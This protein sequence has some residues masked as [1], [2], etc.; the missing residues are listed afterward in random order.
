MEKYQDVILDHEGNVVLDA[1]VA[2]VNQGTAVAST[3]YSDN[4]ITPKAN[5]FNAS[6]VDGSFSFYAAN[7]RYDIIVLASASFSGKRIDD[8][9]L[10]D[11]ST[12]GAVDQ[13]ADQVVVGTGTGVTS[14]PNFTYDPDT[15]DLSAVAPT[16]TG[17]T[18][19]GDVE[20]VAGS[21]TNT[22]S[23]A[24]K[25][26]ISSGSATGGN[27]GDV[28]LQIAG[29]DAI[30]LGGA[31]DLS[32]SFVDTDGTLAAN[33]DNKLPTQKAVKT[34]ADTTKVPKTTTVNGHALSGDITVTA[35]DVGAPSG[36]GVST[37]TNTGDET[38][39][40]IGALINAAVS[41]N[42]PVDADQIGLMDS[43]ASNILKKLSW[44]NVKATLKTYFDTL[45]AAI[46]YGVI[47][48]SSNT[49]LAA[50]DYS[51][52]IVFTSSFTQTL[53]AAATLADG[54]YVNFVNVGTGN[55]TVD[56]NSSELINGY[57]TFII[58]PGQSGR[59]VTDGAAFY[60]QG[61]QNA[62]V[63]PVTAFGAVMNDT[64]ASIRTA[65]KTALVAALAA[66][67][68]VYIPEG[69]LYLPADAAIDVPAGARVIGSNRF[70][71]ASAIRGDGKIFTITTAGGA[72]HRGFADLDIANESTRGIL[73]ECTF[74]TAITRM[75]FDDIRFGKSTHHVYATGADLVNWA[76]HDC[77][78]EDSNTISRLLDGAATFIEH[79]CYT[80]ANTGEGLHIGGGHTV[81]EAHI[82][83]SVFE[84]T[85]KSAIVIE[86]N[87]HD[88]S[89]VKMDTVHFESNG[90]NAGE[91]DVQITANSANYIRGIY[92]DNCGYWGPTGSQ[93]V[94]I[95]ISAGTG[96]IDFVRVR[97]GVVD[98][99]VE[100]APDAN[101]VSIDD[102]YYVSKKT[103]QSDTGSAWAQNLLPANAGLEVWQRGAH[104]SASISVA[105]STAAYT[106]DRWA[107]TTAANEAS[108]VAQSTG[109]TNRSRWS[110]K[111]QKNNGQTGTGAMRF[112]Y[113]FELDEIVPARGQIVTL[114][115]VLKAG[116]NWSPAS[117]NISIKLYCGTGAAAKRGAGYTSETTPISVTQAITTT[118][119]RYAYTSSVVVPT[120]TTQMSLAIEWTPV[121]T[122][123]ADDSFY[124]DDVLLQLGAASSQ[125]I[126]RSFEADLAACY[127]HYEKSYD[128]DK[129]PGDTG[130]SGRYITYNGNL[131]GTAEVNALVFL[132][133]RKRISA[134]TITTY[135]MAGTSGKYA[136]VTTAG[137]GITNGATPGA[138]NASESS[139]AFTTD[140]STS[141]YG[142]AFHW[143]VDAGIA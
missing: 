50:A 79:A 12:T 2:V 97:G 121:G 46:R 69:T 127:R 122:A 105:A 6:A 57:T 16:Q 11:G 93:T 47:A 77:K 3:I 1:R 34:Y 99:S 98:G 39:A 73:I 51:K 115:L 45:Y 66:V 36:S 7:G 17:S 88:V 71:G 83:A 52:T 143:T 60:V 32:G 90:S 41:K 129:A 80:T 96:T 102:V 53:T 8:V 63:L 111:V 48:R 67:K 107:L 141:K 27:S 37:G 70:S 136:N 58:R 128:L 104:G 114:G 138:T 130:T 10:F 21:R 44:A 109:L 108:T 35:S 124:I 4:G 87:G 112:E 125:F 91:A 33:S 29:V 123:G 95:G 30:R 117:G 76:F 92:L 137:G 55:I 64:G 119:K 18:A 26:T 101:N 116:A 54:W 75:Q 134:N 139:F 113:P 59:I 40:T 142:C 132:K 61:L 19:S 9:I 133:V 20:L 62:G 118:A 49:I 13:P 85:S 42:P 120:T 89:T 94:R 25:V 74:N 86:A 84:T 72:E 126:P 110:A 68:T 103:R 14:S 56:P 28:A 140:N 65:N 43:A 38:T 106:A 82:L 24:G 5:P 22:L 81:F 15:G 78:F 23:A 131:T 135:D 31:G 100:L